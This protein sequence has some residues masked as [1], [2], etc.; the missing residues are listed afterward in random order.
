M[1]VAVLHMQGDFLTCQPASGKEGILLWNGEIFNGDIE[2]PDGKSDT[3][4]IS[5][6]LDSLSDATDFLSE[7]HEKLFCRIEGPYSFIYYKKSA[8]KLYYCKDIFG[9]RSLLRCNREDSI[10]LCSSIISDQISQP[11][12]VDANFIYEIDLN[13]RNVCQYHRSCPFPV[14]PSIQTFALE[15][16]DKKCLELLEN[17]IRSRVSNNRKGQGSTVAILFSGGL[18]STL[19]ARLSDKVLDPDVLIELINVSF[20]PSNGNGL[21]SEKEIPDRISAIESFSELERLSC[22]RKW[23]FSPLN[24]T[25]E[26]YQKNRSRIRSLIAPANTAMDLS[27]AAPFWVASTWPSVGFHRVL[28]LSKFDRHGLEGLSS[29]ISLDLNRMWHRNLGRDDR[30][31]SDGGREARYPFL[32]EKLVH[33]VLGQCPISVRMDLSLPRGLGEKAMLRRIAKALGLSHCVD[34][35]KRAVQFGTR[36]SKMEG[37]AIKCGT[38]V[39]F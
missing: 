9:R 32:D 8:H 25:I 3:E 5:Q 20:I 7:L 4:V 30:V 34:L 6:F 27:I 17:S 1:G 13:T 19:L 14:S 12:E 18:D 31:L 21:L 33:F 39:I 10:L 35:P 11:E 37:P 24:V 22:S 26:E 28:L 29:E 23:I 36:S 38:D 15:Y 2:I 16:Y